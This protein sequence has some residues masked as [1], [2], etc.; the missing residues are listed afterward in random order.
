[1]PTPAAKTVSEL[2]KKVKPAVRPTVQAARR[3]VKAA[4]PKATE[5]A[6]RSRP[7]RSPSSMFKVIR[8]T[9][10]DA[11]VVGV[12]A[13]AKHASLFFRRGSELDDDSGLLEGNGK[14]RYITLRR[15]ADATRPAVKRLVRKAV[16]LEKG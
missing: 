11:Q 1:M 4:A 10:D 14:S 15:P 8:F 7:P 5:I 6:Y 9:I 3:T 16:A 12:G 2:L 13:F